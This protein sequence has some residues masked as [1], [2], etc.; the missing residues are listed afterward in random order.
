VGNPQC[1]E[2]G[3]EALDAAGAGHGGKLEEGGGGGVNRR[4]PESGF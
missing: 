1:V 4:I 3:P 2:A